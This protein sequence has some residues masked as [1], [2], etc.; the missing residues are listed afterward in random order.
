MFRTIVYPASPSTLQV[1]QLRTFSTLIS[2]IFKSLGVISHCVC[3]LQGAVWSC[4]L[5]DSAIVAATGSADFSAKIWDALNGDELYSFPH[6]HIVR[7]VAFA[8]MT[9]R[10]VTGGMRNCIL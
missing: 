1:L 10:L 3:V 4:V 8:H 5:N 6:K 7:T 9:P 2:A